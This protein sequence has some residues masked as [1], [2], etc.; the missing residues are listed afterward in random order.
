[1]IVLFLIYPF[2]LSSEINNE[3][4]IHVVNNGP[5]LGIL[6]KW[7]DIKSINSFKTLLG[8]ALNIVS[9][10]ICFYFTFIFVAV[11]NIQSYTWLIG[12]I[13]SLII[14]F[15]GMEIAIEFLISLLFAF[16]RNYHIAT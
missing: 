10:L 6:K 11:W 7:E 3:L 12:F 16:R 8:I 1:M 9:W 5:Q 2:R 13:S 15:I 14:E 4:Y